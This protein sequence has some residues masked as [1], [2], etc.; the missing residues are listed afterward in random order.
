M[1]PPAPKAA[2]EKFVI[3][4][5]AIQVEHDG[6]AEDLA[7]KV[8]PILPPG[9]V[10]QEI[11]SA[12]NDVVWP[13]KANTFQ[14]DMMTLRIMFSDAVMAFTEKHKRMIGAKILNDFAQAGGPDSVGHYNL[15][16]VKPA[17]SGAAPVK[18]YR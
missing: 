18:N 8:I 16:H 13:E 5:I 6:S 1:P 9:L 15:T 14:T 7:R 4:G 3:E 11:R 10:L 17:T 2:P 12:R